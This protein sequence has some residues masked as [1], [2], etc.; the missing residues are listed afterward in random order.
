[1]LLLD[2]RKIWRTCANKEIKEQLNEI[3]KQHQCKPKEFRGLKEVVFGICDGDNK[4]DPNIEN[5]FHTEQYSYENYLLNPINLY[6]VLKHALPNDA[7]I[8]EMEDAKPELKDILTNINSLP[9]K[10]DLL[11]FILDNLTEKLAAFGNEKF[12]TFLNYINSNDFT[13]TDPKT[14]PNKRDKEIAKEVKNSYLSD[15]DVQVPITEFINC[16]ILK[17]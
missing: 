17:R 9:D 8:Q 16:P 2:K 13:S 7:I 14:D 3:K 11:Q 15:L 5:F 4:K 6:F 1:M 10:V 12:K